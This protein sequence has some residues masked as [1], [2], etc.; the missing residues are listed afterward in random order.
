M[1]KLVSCSSSLDVCGGALSQQM[2]KL[3]ASLPGLYNIISF[4]GGQKTP[5]L[6]IGPVLWKHLEV[7]IKV[8]SELRMVFIKV[9]QNISIGPHTKTIE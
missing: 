1:L 2:V 7:V 4:S 9:C 6:S 8:F 5:V 3:N